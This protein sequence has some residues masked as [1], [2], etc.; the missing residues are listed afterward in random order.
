MT[1]NTT[2][3]INLVTEF[4]IINCETDPTG[5]YRQ[6]YDM[7]EFFDYVSYYKMCF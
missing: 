1:L 7:T 3:E 2:S 6:D 5:V 4:Y